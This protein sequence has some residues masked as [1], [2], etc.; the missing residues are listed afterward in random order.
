MLLAIAALVA[1]LA[2]CALAYSAEDMLSAPRPH[3]PV[4]HPSG[5]LVLHVVDHWD[6][7]HDKMHRNIS[8]LSLPSGKVSHSISTV[9]AEASEVFW[10][11]DDW[12]Y[13]NGT[14]VQRGKDGEVVH[15]FPQGVEANSVEHARGQL[16]F[17]GQMWEGHQF[18]DTDRLD[19]EYEQRGD[20]GVVFDELF[21]RYVDQVLR[22]CH[23][24][25]AATSWRSLTDLYTGIG[26]HGA[27][28][29]RA[30]QSVSSICIPAFTRI[31]SQRERSG[32]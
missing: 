30:G 26:I 29:A 8:I 27:R 18:E 7:K 22:M 17:V 23:D 9:P 5:D 3:A 32:R 10:I 25:R 31:S 12:A 11:E 13:L 15:R 2:P 21:V 6:S 14:T 24:W 20:T 4:L 16:V 1:G 28:P 19:K